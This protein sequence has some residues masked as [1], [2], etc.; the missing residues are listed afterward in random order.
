M[1]ILEEIIQ[2]SKELAKLDKETLLTELNIKDYESF[3][4]VEIYRELHYNNLEELSKNVEDVMGILGQY[5]KIANET[6]DRAIDTTKENY[7]GDYFVIESLNIY[8]KYRTKYLQF[9]F[10]DLKK[11]FGNE[12][13]KSQTQVLN[14]DDF[15]QIINP[16]IKDV[17]KELFDNSHFAESV[18]AGF[19]EINS[20]LKEYL[21]E[22]TGEELDGIKLMHRVFNEKE[23]I[24]EI[25]DGYNK[26]TEEDK[27]NLQSGYHFLLVGAIQG[28]R[29]PNAHA[30]IKIPKELA[31]H[32][33]FLASL[34]MIKIEQSIHD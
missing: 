10:E 15:W 5:E 4:D 34:L 11:E 22:K 28:I 6:R 1:D 16:K 20:L 19:K 27:K 17:S 18:G 24:I 2:L 26:I 8:D 33:I 3:L 12:S 13:P 32:F 14:L 30:N 21:K 23:P 29:N 31:I 25:I 9:S 7:K